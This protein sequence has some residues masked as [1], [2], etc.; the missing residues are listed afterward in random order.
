MKLGIADRLVLLSILPKEG[1]LTTV[2]IVH[3]LRQTLSFTEEEHTDLGIRT[4]GDQVLWSSNG[5]IKDVSIGLKAQVL[6]CDELKKLDQ[7]KT[8]TEEHLPLYEKFV[9]ES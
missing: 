7:Q 1:D 4:E 3:E 5:V 6:I 9:E 2:R 8:L